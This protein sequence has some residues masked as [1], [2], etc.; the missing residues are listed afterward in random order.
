MGR[1]RGADLRWVS[2]DGR[3]GAQNEFVRQCDSGT[4]AFQ[5]AAMRDEKG[6]RPAKPPIG[7]DEAADLEALD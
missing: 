5:G 6:L 2:D 7:Q 1:A 4:T 3:D